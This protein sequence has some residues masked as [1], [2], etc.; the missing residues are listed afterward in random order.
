MNFFRHFTR[1]RN[2]ALWRVTFRSL[3][4]CL[5]KLKKLDLIR[6]K[7]QKDKSVDELKQIHVELWLAEKKYS[8]LVESF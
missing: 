3:V 7:I 8:Q 6:T 5:K 2:D 1:D 4:K